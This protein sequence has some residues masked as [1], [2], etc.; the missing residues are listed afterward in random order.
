[1]SIE[2][3]GVLAGAQPRTRTLADS[4]RVAVVC[5]AELRMRY[6]PSP[7]DTTVRVGESFGPSLELYTCG[8]LVR[9]D[10]R[11]TWHARDLRALREE[12]SA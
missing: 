3:T 1:M 12:G 8:G 6:S 5:T 10:E 7:P 2:A 9:V 11:L 4:V